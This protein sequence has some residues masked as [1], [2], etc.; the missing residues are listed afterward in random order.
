MPQHKR[1]IYWLDDILNKASTLPYATQAAYVK[2]MMA[3]ISRALIAASHNDNTIKHELQGYPIGTTITMQVLPQLAS[4]TLA[5]T[6]KHHLAFSQQPSADLTLKFKHLSLAFLVFSFQEGTAQSFANDRM[7]ADGELAYAIRFVRV[8][9]RLEA[10]I[11]PKMIANRAIKQYPNLL[12]GNKI[13]LASK[14]YAG[15]VKT[16]F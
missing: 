6:P 13:S 2:L 8:L 11:L 12:L 1:T 7:V 9:N 15:V 5:V 3:V 14:V 16:F 10:V 4:F